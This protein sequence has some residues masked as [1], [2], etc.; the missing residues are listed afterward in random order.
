MLIL[1]QIY[2]K[3]WNYS[4]WFEDYFQFFAQLPLKCALKEVEKEI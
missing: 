3:N 4:N 1:L 2:K